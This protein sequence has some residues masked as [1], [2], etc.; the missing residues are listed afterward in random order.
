MIVRDEL[1]KALSR[2]GVKRLEVAAGELFDPTRHEAMMRQASDEIDS[3]H[4]TSQLQPGYT[5]GDKTI[6]P[7]KVSVAE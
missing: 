7:A 6:R 2:F 1:L 3:N 4:V 5:L